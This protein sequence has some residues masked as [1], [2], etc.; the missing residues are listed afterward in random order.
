[1]A[2]LNKEWWYAFGGSFYTE[3]DVVEFIFERI[4]TRNWKDSH[5]DLG[6]YGEPNETIKQTPADK[7]EIFYNFMMDLID[8]V[9][10]K[11]E[12]TIK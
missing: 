3:E 10:Q 6:G 5:I 2:K 11:S 1:M 8:R 7:K 12:N 9:N 4:D